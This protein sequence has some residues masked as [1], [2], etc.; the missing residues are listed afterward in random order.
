[1][2]TVSMSAPESLAAYAGLATAISKVQLIDSAP[3]DAYSV[4]VSAGSGTLFTANTFASP[5]SVSGS[6][7]S[8]VTITGSFLQVAPL[9]AALDYTGTASGHDTITVNVTDQ[10]DH[11]SAVT[12]IDVTVRPATIFTSIDDPLAVNGGTIANGINNAGQI[13]GNFFD[14]D[15]GFDSFFRENGF[16]YSA[17]AFTTINDP[18]RGNGGSGYS[19]VVQNINNAGEMVGYL[20][21]RSLIT[22]GLIVDDYGFIYN[23]TFQDFSYPAATGSIVPGTSSG[24]LFF[25]GI[26]N[27][28]QIVGYYNTSSNAEGP[29]PNFAVPPPTYVGF[30]YQN[31]TSQT[32]GPAG[33]MPFGIN[34]AAQVVGQS[35]SHG[36]LYSNGAFSLFDDPNGSSTT[37]RDINN[38]GEIVGYYQ[39][40]SVTH[41]FAY[42]PTS[43]TWT[44]IDV[45]GA[46]STFVYGVNDSN[47][48]VGSYTDANNNSHGFV[49]SIPAPLPAVAGNVDEWLLVNGQWTASAQPGSHPAGSHVA[50]VAD[51]TGD[52]TSDI[53]W[54]NVST[55][56]VGLWKMSNGGWAGSVDLGTHPGSGWQIAGAGDFNHDGTSDVLW[57]NAGS[58]Q[59][60][61]WQLS[62]GQWAASVQPGPHP[63]GYQ[64]AGIGD[65]NRD[66][67]SDVL[68]FNPTTR[69]VD[70]WNIV[71]GH[72]AGSNDIGIYPSAGYQIAGV[73]DFNNDGASD[74]FWYNPSTGATDIWLLQNGHWAASVS[75]GNHPTGY[76]VAGIGDFNGDGTSD[77]LF[78]NPTTHDVDEWQIANG[79]WAGS[80]G[81]GTHPGSAQIAG[82]GDFNGSL[83]SDVLWHQFV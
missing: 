17:G 67:T 42:N 14:A 1:M 32:I 30:I 73:G 8:S 77:V 20:E 31:G 16:L 59:T 60:D 51:F 26:N 63:L 9:V 45:P 38:A 5:N 82:I 44:T 21:T 58:G 53:L 18:T 72:W 48:I 22:H 33:T 54:Q 76:Q 35:G 10:T 2:S 24:Q 34:D 47:Q 43:G 19:S 71:N 50:G 37:A 27:S 39:S 6:G 49:G 3:G 56:A 12:S 83:V 64:V 7:S 57:F 13:A 4:V 29:P 66:G 78:Y 23:G 81:L 55:G 41:G 65:F 52:G 36:F 11:S 69:D 28:N 25:E 74:V 46:T 15:A 61:I 75:P 40:Q 79:H 62:N 68:W 70:D 80:V